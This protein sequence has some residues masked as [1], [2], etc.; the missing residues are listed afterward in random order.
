MLADRGAGRQLN[1]GFCLLYGEGPGIAGDIPIE[2]IIV[3]EIAK[4]ARCPIGALIDMWSIVEKD[5]GAAD[6]DTLAV[7]DRHNR[8]GVVMSVALHLEHFEA[9]DIVEAL[10]VLVLRRELALDA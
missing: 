9:H 1:D 3:G 6:A 5:I 2:F 4:L 7:A 8:V 10:V